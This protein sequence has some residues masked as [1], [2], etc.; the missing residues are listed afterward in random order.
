[1]TQLWMWDSFA[2]IVTERQSDPATDFFSSEA[3][4]K[5]TSRNPS[6]QLCLAETN[7][8]AY[9]QKEVKQLASGSIS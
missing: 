5:L 6:V 1:M 2:V 3:N 8:S 4:E 9:L 7:S